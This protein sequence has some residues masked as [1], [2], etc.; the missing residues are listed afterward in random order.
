[1]W[2]LICF[3]QPFGEKESSPHYRFPRGLVSHLKAARGPLKEEGTFL[4]I[5]EEAEAEQALE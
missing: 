4:L 3:A 1:M 5:E 2:K